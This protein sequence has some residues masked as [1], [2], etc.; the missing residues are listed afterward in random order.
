MSED[1]DFLVIGGGSGGI[2]AAR[3]ASAHGA[4]TGLIEGNAL[5]GTCVN[6]GCVPKKVMWNAAH[7]SELMHDA[8]DYG[9]ALADGPAIDWAQLKEKRAAYIERLNGI[10]ARNLANDEVTRIEGWA[11]FVDTHTVEVGE[12]RYT[13]RHILIATGGRPAVPDL[14]GAELGITSDGFFALE[15]QPQKVAVIGA[16]YIAVELAGIFDALGSEV[17]ML[18][19]NE[20]FLRRFDSLL[21]DTLMEEMSKAGVSV[22]THLHMD[23]IERDANGCLTLHTRDGH[24]YTGFDA[25]VWATGRLPNTQSLNLAATGLQADDDGHLQVD[26]FQ[27]THVEGIY[28][29]GDVT[30]VW[31]LTPVAIAAGRRLAD[32]LFGGEPG[33]R[34]VYENIPT[35]VFS[36]PPLGTVGLTEEQ[37]HEQF[38]QSG[39]KCYTTRFTDMYHAMTQRKPATAMKL[40]T[41]G[42]KERVVGAHVIGLHADEMIQGFAVAVRM[43]AT[44]RDFDNTVAIHPTASEEL[45]TMR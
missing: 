8:S 24:R 2:A 5:G 28:A 9:F 14:P 18:L 42:A 30:G 11:R 13:A 19:R 26:A 21:R 29:V 37:A 25:V 17:N 16:G 39:V 33:A 10:Y 35:V 6:V 41:V 3:R 27:Q 12:R 45:V 7:L 31:Q 23:A 15:Q 38:G 43:G 40:V 1:F 44:K 32:R 34:L 36:H 22:L 20:V 4:K